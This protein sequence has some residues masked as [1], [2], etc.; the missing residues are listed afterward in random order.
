MF[1]AEILRLVKSTVAEQD[2]I[3]GWT[4]EPTAEHSSTLMLCSTDCPESGSAKLPSF[5]ASWVCRSRRQCACSRGRERGDG[6]G[7]RPRVCRRRPDFKHSPISSLHDQVDP[8]GCDDV[9]LHH[10]LAFTARQVS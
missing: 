9:K 8:A 4:D 6:S 5:Y 3:G 1:G 7:G 10:G 2:R